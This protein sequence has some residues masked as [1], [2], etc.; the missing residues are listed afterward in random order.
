MNQLLNY[1]AL[2]TGSSEG[3]GF[4]I[5]EA[6]ARNGSDIWLVARN[7]EKLQMAGERL[8]K[9]N[10]DIQSTAID[11]LD[12]GVSTSL[13]NAIAKKWKF[14]NVLVNN[15]GVAQFT[16]FSQVSP[17]ELD[18]QLNLNV[19]V[20]YQLTQSLLPQLIQTQ[21]CVINISSYFA[22]RMIPGKPSTAYSLTKGAINS[23]TKSLACELGS[24][25]IRVNAI[26]PGTI[27][28]PMYERNITQNASPEK[29]AAFE[30]LVQTI[31]PLQR[32]GEPED[33]GNLAVYLVSDAA[34]WITGAIFNIDGGLTTN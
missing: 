1:K 30:R 21:G 20:P 29:M 15:A 28:T 11:L 33:I 14:L 2:I 16:P 13:A 22:Q 18:L 7:Q 17:R 9:Y 26:A 34:K 8:A 19:K 31:Y 32:I 4:G 25:G 27:R 12:E 23:F 6:Y 24:N 5:A 10:V 3:I